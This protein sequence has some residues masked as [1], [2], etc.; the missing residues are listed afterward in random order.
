[1]LRRSLRLFH[2]RREK[3]RRYQRDQNV[4]STVRKCHNCNRLLRPQE[5]ETRH[6]CGNAECPS[7][8]Q[9]H[10]LRRH[11]YY[12]QNPTKLE[13]KRKFLK[14]RKRKADGSQSLKEKD[15]L[16]VFWDSETTQDS[17]VQV[18]NMVC[19]ATSNCDEV[20]HFKGITCNEEFLDW[21]RE[22]AQDF[23][24]TFLAHNSQGVDSY[25]ILDALYKHYVV[26]QKIVNAA[27]MSSLSINGGTHCVQRLAAVLLPNALVLLH[28]SLWTH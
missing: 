25:L 8:K 11:Q 22:L 23:K 28:Q 17:D 16:S 27:K 26:P 13:E 5:I 10:D 3:C 2:H 21:L 14:S 18:P 20:F 24:L 1:M 7:R 12:I 4:C 19:A 15:K 9:Y 6:V